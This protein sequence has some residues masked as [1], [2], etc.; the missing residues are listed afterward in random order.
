MNSNYVI[1]GF[2]GVGKSTAEQKKRSV[3][4]MESSIFSWVWEAGVCKGRNEQFTKDY[5][6]YLV[7]KMEKAH[8]HIF[9]LSCHKEVR[10]ELK[11]RGIPYII[12]LP[13]K[14]QKNEYLKRWLIRGS[15]HEFIESMNKRWEDMIQSCEED[16]SPKIYLEANEHIADILPY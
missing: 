6:D 1:C 16:D 4:D 10:E 2:S 5:I 13:R 11:N 14:E 7:K 15:D 9:L 8:M 12:V 3:T